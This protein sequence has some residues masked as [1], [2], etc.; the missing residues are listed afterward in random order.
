MM[1]TRTALCWLM[2]VS[3]A[4]AAACAVMGASPTSIHRIWIAVSMLLM[5]LLNGYLW[6]LQPRDIAARQ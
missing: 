1:K 6:S 2:T 4:I 5:V 3:V